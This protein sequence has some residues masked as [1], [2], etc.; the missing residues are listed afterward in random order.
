MCVVHDRELL[1]CSREK[2]LAVYIHAASSSCNT[3]TIQSPRGAKEIIYIRNT[4][5][6]KQVYYFFQP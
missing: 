1:I 2:I 4:V 5:I 3:H 6:L